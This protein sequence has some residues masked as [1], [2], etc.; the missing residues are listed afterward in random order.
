M[1]AQAEPRGGSGVWDFLRNLSEKQKGSSSEQMP[2]EHPCMRIG[3]YAAAVLPAALLLYYCTHAALYAGE[4]HTFILASGR[5]YVVS[6]ICFL[7]IVLALV[8]VRLSEHANRITSWGWFV[9]APFAVYFSLLYMNASKYSI[10]FFELNR[11]ALVLTFVFLFLFE[12]A[13]L[14]LM[15]SI[16]FAVVTMAVLIAALGIA[17]SFVISFRGMALSAADLF[18]LGAAA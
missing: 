3:R 14:I 15:G 10:K 4:H 1:S 5:T 7:L 16:R 17:N 18:S 6:L 11:I 9:L 12:T 13:V 8:P 2:E